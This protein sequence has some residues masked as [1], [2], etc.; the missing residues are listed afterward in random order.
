MGCWMQ[1]QFPY[2]CGF[3]LSVYFIFICIFFLIYICSSFVI[4]ISC[5]VWKSVFF[6]Y[7]FLSKSMLWR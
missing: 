4:F 5:V 3:N 7:S 1:W 6:L 2:F